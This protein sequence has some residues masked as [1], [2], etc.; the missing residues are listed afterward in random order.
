MSLEAIDRVCKQEKSNQQSSKKAS[1]KGKK[2]SKQPGTESMIRVP[3]KACTKKHCNLYKKHGGVYTTHN[4]RDCCKYEK[5]RSEKAHFCTAKKGG[6]K[7]NPTKQSFA[8]LS[9]KLD[10]LEKVIKKQ[11]TKSKKPRRDNS[12]SNSK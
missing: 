5:D 8:Q 12:N 11:S 6:K 9:K 4:I 2:G 1:N 7:P 3:K 10:K